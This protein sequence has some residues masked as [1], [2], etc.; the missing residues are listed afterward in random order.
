[1]INCNRKLLLTK[2]YSITDEIA[3]EMAAMITLM[4]SSHQTI[5]FFSAITDN[6]LS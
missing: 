5:D 4:S 1:M 2:L 6:Y 3:P